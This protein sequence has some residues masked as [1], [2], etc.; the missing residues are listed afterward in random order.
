V[1]GSS[2]LFIVVPVRIVIGFAVFVAGCL[3]INQPRDEILFA[4]FA[5]RRRRFVRGRSII[6]AFA[7]TVP[8]KISFDSLSETNQRLFSRAHFERPTRGSST[9]KQ[10][11]AGKNNAPHLSSIGLD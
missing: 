7:D 11:L 1:L 4:T 10:S 2:R 8:F 5:Q 3:R 6:A 9:R